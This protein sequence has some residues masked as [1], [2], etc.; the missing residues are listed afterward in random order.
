MAEQDPTEAC[1]RSPCISSTSPHPTPQCPG[2]MG[3]GGVWGRYWGGEYEGGIG[4]VSMGEVLEG[5]LWERYWRRGYGRGIGV[6][7]CVCVEELLGRRVW[8][9]YWR[10]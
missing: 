4:G 6:C 7:V 1:L 3:G 2:G 8:G 10:G 9:K 5:G